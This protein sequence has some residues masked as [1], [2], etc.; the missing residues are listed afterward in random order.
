LKKTYIKSLVG[1][2]PEHIAYHTVLSR[3]RG[4][5]YIQTQARSPGWGHSEVV[6]PK[7]FVPRQMI[8]TRKI[9]KFCK[10]S[11]QSV[12]SLRQLTTP[13]HVA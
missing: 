9:N 12:K 5:V 3:Q 13:P 1:S 10:C 6:P 8:Q 2:F 11:F 7:F 4:F